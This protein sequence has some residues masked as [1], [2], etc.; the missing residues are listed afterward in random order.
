MKQWEK[1]EYFLDRGIQRAFDPFGI[2][3]LGA[4]HRSPHPCSEA[5]EPGS[6]RDFLPIRFT[7]RPDSAA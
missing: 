2:A 4:V 5:V 7:V 3:N 6:A 1:C